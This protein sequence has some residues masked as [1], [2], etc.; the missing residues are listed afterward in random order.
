MTIKQRYCCFCSV[1]A[2]C[3]ICTWTYYEVSANWLSVDWI[4]DCAPAVLRPRAIS[5]YI[6]R[7]RIV[8]RHRRYRYSLIYAYIKQVA[9]V[10][11][12][13]RAIVLL[14]LNTCDLSINNTLIWTTTSVCRPPTYTPTYNTRHGLAWCSTLI[15]AVRLGYNQQMDIMSWVRK[16]RWRRYRKPTS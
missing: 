7:C 10:G 15:V 6:Y 12:Q 2:A 13:W 5:E 14:K 4:I 11:W 16:R 8:V 1:Y 9:A 3:F